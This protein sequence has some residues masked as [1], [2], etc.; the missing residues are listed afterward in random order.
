MASSLSSCPERAIF[1]VDLLAQP[2][3]L[4]QKHAVYRLSQTPDTR[5]LVHHL[6]MCLGYVVSHAALYDCEDT[7]EQENKTPPEETQRVRKGVAL[8][9]LEPVF[10]P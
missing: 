7:S 4:R 8:T 6:F 5:S 9:G 10:S 1:G 3:R 2:A